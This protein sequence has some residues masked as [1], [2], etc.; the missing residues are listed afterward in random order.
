MEAVQRKFTALDDQFGKG[1]MA[2]MQLTRSDRYR[3][4]ARW[5]TVDD[6]EHGRL[7][8]EVRQ[9]EGRFLTTIDS[10]AMAYDL[11]GQPLCQFRIEG[12]QMATISEISTEEFQK[13]GDRDEADF[14]TKWATFDV[15]RCWLLHIEMIERYGGEG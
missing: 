5:Y 14:R 2:V 13:M 10:V 9:I 11:K 6:W 8:E 3:I 12:I 7:V 4:G 1:N 15:K